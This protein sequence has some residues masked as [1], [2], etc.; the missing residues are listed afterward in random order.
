MSAPRANSLFG[1]AEVDTL[2]SQVL[3]MVGL[4][5]NDDLVRSM[6][7]TALEMDHAHLDR[8]ELKIASQT[9]AEMLHAWEVFAPHRSKPKVTVFGSARTRPDDPDYRLT[10][11]LGRRM[12]EA[13]WMTITGGGPGIMTA[14]I[15]GAGAENSFGVNI[16]LP[17]EQRAAQ[18]IDDDPK[19][20]TFKY[21]FTRKLT[22]VKESD[23]FVLVPGGFGTLDEAFELLTLVQTGKSYPLPVVLLDHPGST[24]WSGFLRFVREELLAGGKISEADLGL[25]HHTHD[26]AEAAAHLCQF[27]AVYH[28][29]RYVGRTLVIRMRRP[30]DDDVL[31]TLV[32]EFGDLLAS[33]SIDRIE[34]TGPEL[35]DD[36]HVELPRLGLRFDQRSY[37]RLCAMIHRLNQLAGP[38]SPTPAPDLVHDVEPDLPTDDPLDSD[39]DDRPRI[40]TT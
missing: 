35:R 29:M 12:T 5:A 17:F 30:I 38:T 6:V 28:S 39:A 34:T 33:G 22:F 27:Y 14:G 32:A 4:D 3:D 20:A 9:L 8:L 37:G 2:I 25:F 15:E 21:F 10:V 13:G 36:D 16:V 11:D 31:A 26:A 18:I 23:G 24:Y 19:L 40:E 7:V 1:Q